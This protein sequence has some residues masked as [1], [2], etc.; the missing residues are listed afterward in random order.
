MALPKSDPS[1]VNIAPDRVRRYANLADPRLGAK[2]IA[3]SDEFFGAKDR[4][5]NPEPTVFIPGKYD[6]HGK[7]VDGWETRCRRDAGFDWCVVKL[8]RPGV[9]K[10]IDLE[11][12]HFIGNFPPAA[13][14]DACH[15][16]SGDPTPLTDWTEIVPSTTLQGNSLHFL[17]VVST[18]PFT[19]VRLNIYPDGGIARLR[20]YG[21]PEREAA[22]EGELLDLAAIENGS[23]VVH[24]NNQYF[25]P[26]SSLLMPGRG[27][28]MSDGWET[29]R[30]REPGNDWCIV[31]LAQPGMIR[32][33]EVDTAHFK[34]NY[35]HRC[36]LRAAD[37]R[38]GGGN[39]DFLITQAMFWPILLPEQKLQMDQQHFFEREILPLGTVTYA[40]FNIF[41]DGGVSRLRLWGIP[42]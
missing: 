36:S 21:R 29:R 14:L 34:G 25:G 40:C 27:T 19:H 33:I 23:Y 35:P 18:Q 8:G 22:R 6:E 28:S 39:E 12:T 2:A 7:W 31:A 15:A 41:P 17:D 5:L 42:R 3:A 24:A 9:I 20:V 11:T 13:S 30:R 16:A 26:A 37:V 38:G 32:K 1:L 4:M 10:G